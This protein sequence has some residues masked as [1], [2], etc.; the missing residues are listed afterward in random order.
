MK[1]IIAT[2]GIILC[3]G[4]LNAE[5]V[6]HKFELWEPGIEFKKDTRA[7]WKMGLYWGWTN[8]FLQKRGPKGGPLVDCLETMSTDQA[9]AM[10]DKY[11]KDHPEKWSGVFS[12]QILAA[13][14]VAGSP[15]EGKTPLR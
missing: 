1:P 3:C 9:I 2:L 12:E 10:V 15:C 5:S 8:G 7:I 6:L 11:Y 13:L 4:F 14:T